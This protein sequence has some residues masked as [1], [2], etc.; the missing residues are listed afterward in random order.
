[1]IDT[2]T[3]KVMATVPVGAIAVAV[4]PDGKHVYVGR[5]AIDAATNTVGRPPSRGV[6][7]PDGKH[8]YVTNFIGNAVSVIDTTTIPR[9]WWR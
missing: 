8:A 5:G 6:F 2:A 9:P 1:V 7:T 4:S 3:N